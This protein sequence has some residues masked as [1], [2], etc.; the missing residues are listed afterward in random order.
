MSLHNGCLKVEDVAK[1]GREKKWRDDLDA[2]QTWAGSRWRRK[3][4]EKS[5]EVVK[6]ALCTNNLCMKV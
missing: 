5:R 2:Y 3:K 1:A 4:V 6:S